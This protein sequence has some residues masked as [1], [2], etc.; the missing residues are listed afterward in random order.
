MQILLTSI[1]WRSI[2]MKKLLIFILLFFTIIFIYSQT[3]N[4]IL[5]TDNK[6]LT[7]HFEETT[8]PYIDSS[9]R[10]NFTVANQIIETVGQINKGIKFNTTTANL[11][12]YNTTYIMDTNYFTLTYWIKPTKEYANIITRQASS[13]RGS[14]SYTGGVVD[15][16]YIYVKNNEG[17]VSCNL[18]IGNLT[19]MGGTWTNGSYHHIG[20]R[21]DGATNN[22]SI[23]FNGIN[24]K[25][26]ACTA[27]PGT[28]SNDTVLGMTS[29]ENPALNVQIDELNV[30][31]RAL[32]DTEMLSVYMNESQ[33]VAYPYA[34]IV[35]P[36]II[37]DYNVS[38][39]LTNE[40]INI[41]FTDSINITSIIFSN[42]ETAYNTSNKSTSFAEFYYKI[43]SG[44]NSC[45]IF[46]QK[47][48][49]LYNNTYSYS[50]MTKVLNNSFIK[51]IYD[52]DYY[53]GLYPFNY[54]YIRN[55]AGTT[56]D[57]WLN[58]YIKYNIYNLSTSSTRYALSF[59]FDGNISI[60][61]QN[62][63]IYYCN[64]TYTT[65]NPA[66]SNSCELIDSYNGLNPK[67]LHPPYSSHT[68]IPF[69][70]NTVT[71]TQTSYF[72]LIS[73]SN[74]I[75]RAWKMRYVTNSTYDNTSFSIGEYTTWT[76]TNRIY[77]IHLHTFLETD[78]ISG[79]VKYFDGTG[80]SNISR[81][82]IDYYNYIPFAPSA[83]QFINPDCTNSS[84]LSYTMTNA[85]NTTIFFSWLAS[86]DFNNESIRYLIYTYEDILNK[87]LLVNTSNL[88]ATISSNSNILFGNKYLEI[89]SY[90]TIG[91]SDYSTLSCTINFCVNNWQINRAPCTD[92]AKLIS[93]YDLNSCY[94]QY[95]IPSDNGT[96][97]SCTNQ[98]TKSIKEIGLILVVLILVLL[99][100]GFRKDKN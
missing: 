48:C 95:N 27:I 14:R 47:S 84:T 77:D 76:A 91:L 36:A 3:I 10:Y 62:L 26:I 5:L 19:H 42:N 54:D 25:S 46:N 34:A 59:E 82:Y 11:T 38:L 98:Q 65:G 53:S 51:T 44:I 50:N 23:W 31:N 68:S 8:V 80:L 16:A 71:K 56:S 70:I 28:L 66:T 99:F 72:I 75:A 12:A 17:T 13:N 29:G 1:F 69:N 15:S 86:N 64:S 2:N 39:N 41:S 6:T 61:S 45:V 74:P 55:T 90:D 43:F 49:L 83:T 60:G 79:F 40:N 89:Y 96:Y 35:P 4:A 92:D 18:Y 58:N 87:I 9:G 85:S 7:L 52:T 30:W 63:L 97:E 21:Y 93:Y 20:A 33:G 88:N 81:T 22:L 57:L 94:A 32:N 78:Y 100:L 37:I 73:L 67:H 24:K